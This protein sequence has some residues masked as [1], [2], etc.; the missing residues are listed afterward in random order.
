VYNAYYH[1]FATLKDL[2]PIADMQQNDHFVKLL[3]RLV[4]EH[5]EQLLAGNIPAGRLVWCI[6]LGFGPSTG[7]LQQV[8]EQQ[9]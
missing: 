3:R 5:C 4:D 6:Q 7:M 8:V 9:Q 2:G 1:G